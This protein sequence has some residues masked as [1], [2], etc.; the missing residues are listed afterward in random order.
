MRNYRKRKNLPGCPVYVRSV[1]GTGWDHWGSLITCRFGVC[2]TPIRAAIVRSCERIGWQAKAPAP[3]KRK[4]L[5][6]KVGQTLSSVNPA[7]SAILSQLL[8]ERLAPTFN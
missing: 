7:I 2:D 3:Q 6:T 4:P 8:R 5:C 1:K